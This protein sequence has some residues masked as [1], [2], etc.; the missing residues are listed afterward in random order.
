MKPHLVPLYHGRNSNLLSNL[1]TCLTA[2]DVDTVIVDGKIVV[3]KKRLLTVE[4]PRLLE[5]CQTLAER[6]FRDVR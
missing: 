3:E 1:V 4:E 2:G 6:R 5:R